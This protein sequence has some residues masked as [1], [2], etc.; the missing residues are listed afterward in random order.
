MGPSI[1][2]I[3]RAGTPD[4]IFILPHMRLQPGRLSPC[5]LAEARWQY[6]NI[7]QFDLLALERNC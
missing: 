1:A 7:R 3:E 4:S 2:Q 5:G 6:Y